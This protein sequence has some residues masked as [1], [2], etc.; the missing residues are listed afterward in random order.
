METKVGIDKNQTMELLSREINGL[1]QRIEL[2]E[3]KRGV[4]ST[5]LERI[6][7]NEYDAEWDKV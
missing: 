1:K 4:V 7:D 5:A 6:W 3:N 2:L